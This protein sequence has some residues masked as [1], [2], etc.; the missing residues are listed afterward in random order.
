LA[1]ISSYRYIFTRFEGVYLILPPLSN[2]RREV[3]EV[4]ISLGVTVSSLSLLGCSNL[5]DDALS[6][7][8]WRMA[9]GRMERE[10]DLKKVFEDASVVNV[11]QGP[12]LDERS[13]GFLLLLPRIIHEIRSILALALLLLKEGI[14]GSINVAPLESFVCSRASAD[15][16]QMVSQESVDN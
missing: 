2:T 15:Q 14:A 9:S 16:P 12:S 10:E 3:N 5:L 13:V 1:S 4:V 8:C 11:D 6:F 7:W